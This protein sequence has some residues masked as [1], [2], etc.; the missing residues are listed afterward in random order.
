MS[1]SKAKAKL[2]F[3]NTRIAFAN[4]SDK[5]LKKANQLFKM[6]NQSAFVNIGS[7]LGL[8]A[9]KMNLPFTKS[10]I[11][12]TIFEHF[13]GGEN[14]LD[15]QGA[16]TELYK[17]NT[18]TVLDYGAESKSSEEDLDSV[19]EE[20][21]RA[22]DFAASNSSVPVVSTK[23]TGLADN[24]L[25][26][27]IQKG[28]K[29]SS[30]QEHELSKLIDRLNA[31]CSRAHELNVGVFIDAEES[32]MQDSIDALV[33]DLMEKY[34]K[35]KIIVYN[36]FQLY[37]KD[38]LAYLKECHEDAKKKGY[39]LGA[40]I[41]RGAYMNKERAAAEEHGYLSPIHDTKEDTDRDFDAAVR[42]CVENYETLAS[43]NATHN[44][45][46]NLLQA[47]L[48]AEMG[49][50]KSHKH[51]NF[52]QLYGMSDYITFNLSKAGYNV[53]K[54]VVYGQIREVIPY[55]IRRAQ[56]NTSVTGEMSRELALIDK[57]MK[58]RGI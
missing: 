10:V 25:L 12:G 14:L 16:I 42:Y 43:C 40:K 57:E 26:I 51:L 48:I 58:R 21:I 9:V 18:L 6:M 41:V 23:V 33:N 13:C 15:C 52:C 53:A 19:M 56:E 46:S 44:L 7:K 11:R 37:R 17:Y 47:K 55:L 45:E 24:D 27:N 35:E 39:I 28:E 54:Y 34:N 31:I 36:T 50:T 20:N 22:I 4:K 30:K 32:W 29:L 49:I 5:Q 2:D 8:F 1:A 38:R 3:S